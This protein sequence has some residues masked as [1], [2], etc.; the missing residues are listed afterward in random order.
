MT[1]AQINRAEMFD[2]V[3]TYL[4]TYTATWSSIPKIVEFKNELDALLTQLDEYQDAQNAAQVFIGKNKRAQKK[5]IAEK[6]DILND[7]LE[8][9][10]SV[11]G[12]AALEAKATSSYSELYV[13]KN[14][15][16]ITTIKELISL[17]EEH[18]ND[19]ATDYGVTEAQITELKQSFDNFQVINGQPRSYQI[20]SAVATSSLED[21]FSKTSDLLD[22]KLDK[23]MKRFK[24][25]NAGF[26]QGYLSARKVVGA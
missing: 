10:A 19:L 15:E 3:Q 5:L 14:E 13:L 8:A 20:A 9:Y 16:F 25:S 1:D 18:L 12:N 17:V 6:A 24:R 11:E 7:T 2:S 21:V 23:I 4:D 22:G 26:Y